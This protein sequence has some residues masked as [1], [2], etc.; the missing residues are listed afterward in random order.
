MFRLYSIILISALLAVDSA[1][2][3]TRAATQRQPVQRSQAS[4]RTVAQ[5]KPQVSQELWK[6]LSDW[7]NATS[8]IKSLYGEHERHVY[9]DAFETEEITEGVFGYQAPDRGRIEMTPIKV[10][11]NL[12]ADRQDP[13]AK[14]ERNK[15]GKPFQLKNGKKERWLCDGE[16]VYDI[17]DERKEAK[18]VQLPPDMRGEN[19]MHSPMPFLFGLP[20]KTAIERFEMKI[21]KDYR[22]ENQPFVVL[23]IRPLSRRDAAN[24]KRAQ[25]MLDTRTF[26]PNAVKLHDPAG[27][28]RTLYKFTKL[29]VGVPFGEMVGIRNPWDPRIKGYQINLLDQTAPNPIANQARPQEGFPN[30]IGMAHNKAEEE[31][32]KA[33]FPKTSIKKLQAGPAPRANMKFKVAAQEPRPGTQL[34][35]RT[36]VVL[37]IYTAPQ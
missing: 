5:T 30:L 28:T 27:T 4:T 31:L 8:Q 20:P 36:Q 35:V 24:Y 29:K 6:L 1:D 2:A 26:L 17:N 16:K 14:I 25:V 32:V 13:K 34:D 11:Q 22:P 3:Q 15:D 12:L 21:A 37:R 19:I 18:V 23:D 10:T 7:S 9:N 33:G